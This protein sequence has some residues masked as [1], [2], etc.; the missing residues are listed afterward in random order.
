MLRKKFY[1]SILVCLS[2]LFTSTAVYC[3]ESVNTKLLEGNSSIYENHYN[4]D[5]KDLNFSINKNDVLEINVDVEL[6]NAT[7][8]NDKNLLKQKQAEIEKIKSDEKYINDL[9]KMVKKG[10][11]PA[12]IAVAE[13]IFLRVTDINGTVIEERPMTN[14]EVLQYGEDDFGILSTT[15]TGTTYSREQLRLYSTLIRDFSEF[16]VQANSY[17]TSSMPSSGDDFISVLWN[18]DFLYNGIDSFSGEHFGD[19]Q[20][21][22]GLCELEE[23]GGAA[24]SFRDTIYIDSSIGTEGVFAGVQLQKQVQPNSTYTFKSVYTRTFSALSFSANITASPTGLTGTLVVSPLAS[25]W[26]LVA[27]LTGYY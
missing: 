1:L 22:G 15:D 26:V 17:W 24:W 9:K 8:I 10:N 14:A 23:T 3:D 21:S 4:I 5:C 7:S 20:V 6:K 25:Q 13:A 2:L 11:N 18:K 12:Q 27:P 19:F 16:W